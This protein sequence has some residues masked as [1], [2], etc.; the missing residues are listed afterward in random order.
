MSLLMA[1]LIFLMYALPAVAA[2]WI[3]PTK[4]LRSP[5]TCEYVD[6]NITNVSTKIKN[7]CY[8]LQSV[9]PTS[10]YHLE[11]DGRGHDAMCVAADRSAPGND[12]KAYKL[13]LSGLKDYKGSYSHLLEASA[14]LTATDSDYSVWFS[15]FYYSDLYQYNDEQILRKIAWLIDDGNWTYYPLSKDYEADDLYDGIELDFNSP[16]NDSNIYRDLKISKDAQNRYYA[17]DIASSRVGANISGLYGSAHAIASRII[18]G[19]RYHLSGTIYYSFTRTESDKGTYQRG[20]HATYA[21]GDNGNGRNNNKFRRIQ[22]TQYFNIIAHAPEYDGNLYIYS[23]DQRSGVGQQWLMYVDRTTDRKSEKAYIRPA[24]DKNTAGGTDMK[25]AEFTIYS[26]SSMSDVLGVI[27]DEDGNGYYSDYDNREQGDDQRKGLLKL[28]NNLD[29]TH[30]RTFYIKET[31][32]PDSLISAEGNK[33]ILRENIIDDNLY[34]VTVKYVYKTGK[35]TVDVSMDGS[36]VYSGTVKGYD[37]D[38]EPGNCYIGNN[39]DGDYV[40]GAGLK[41]TKDTSTGF[42][43]TNTVFS[44]YEGTDTDSSALAYYR[45]ADGWGWYKD[46]TGSDYLGSSYPVLPSAAYTLVEEYTPDYYADTGIPYTVI[47][48]SGWNRVGDNKYSYTFTTEGMSFGDEMTVKCNNDR[49]ESSITIS[50]ASDDKVIE[51]RGFDISYLG[52]GNSADSGDGVP[53]AHVET[54]SMG[55]AQLTDLPLGWYR[56]SETDP[57]DYRLTWAQGVNVRG[58]DAIVHLTSSNINSVTV[59]AMNNL[60]VRIAV[61]KKDAENGELIGGAVF[62]LYKDTDG[63]G[64]LDADEEKDYIELK[65]SD[66]D[67]IVVAE[68]VGVGKYLVRESQAPRGYYRSDD[69]IAFDIT[70]RTTD[71]IIVNGMEMRAYQG[72]IEDARYKAPVYVYKTDSSDSSIKLTGAEFRIYEDSNGNGTYDADTD[73][74]A[75]VNENGKTYDVFFAERNGRYETC[76]DDGTVNS[77]LLSFGTYFIEEVTA[78]E[79]YIRTK[80]IRK[81]VID[82]VDTSELSEPDPCEVTFANDK[83]FGTSLTGVGNSKNVELSSEAVLKDSVR[84]GNLVV[85]RTYTLK[86]ELMIRNEDGSCEHTGITAE[87]SFTVK[88]DGETR[89]SGSVEMKFVLDTNKYKG[90]TL[91]AYESLY[92]RTRLIGSH[93]DINDEGQTVRIPDIGTV[94]TADRTGTHTSPVAPGTTFTDMVRY[95]GLI[96]GDEYTLTGVLVDRETGEEL[97]DSESVLKP[98]EAD[99]IAEVHFELDTSELEGRSIVAFEYIS[100]GSSIVAKHD[101]ITDEDQTVGIPKLITTASSDGNKVMNVSAKTTI[102]DTVHY[103]NL[104]PGRMYVMEGSLMH[105]GSGAVYFDPRNNMVRSEVEFVPETPEGSVEV[106]FVFD[107]SN[108]EEGDKLVV[109]ETG[110]MALDDNEDGARLLLCEHRDPNNKD[111]TVSVRRDVPKT[112]DDGID[113]SYVAGL[114]AALGTVIALIGIGSLMSSRKADSYEKPD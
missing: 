60:S 50:K 78:P 25:G 112:G 37:G 38:G 105:S 22:L 88:A 15:A 9:D 63:D 2:G 57:E 87:K 82:R 35:L 74:T 10:L 27:T 34:K 26:D 1:S 12:G 64:F 80:R 42:D 68:G 30:S 29:G 24:A 86:G 40:D 107:S 96:A 84:Y 65:D 14:N 17:F 11:A 58:S 103:E 110:Y 106:K 45:Y 89:T 114:A 54:N 47:N 48:T 41:V 6:S 77:A 28:D 13:D 85:G 39:P 75:K 71:T 113:M 76:Y 111:Q 32:A 46:R 56:I 66:N 97:A 79:L 81:I 83:D 33:A 55:M 92:Y 95:E 19:D 21:Y 23:P 20:S 43:T 36:K 7:V 31:K 90:K 8:D 104:T 51:G 67:G 73:L 59:S 53:A 100:Y 3:D 99:G 101:D 91:V 102:V 94:L 16:I 108:L 69:V 109:Y 44:L 18:S 70:G 49:V 4:D 93:E 5:L 72:E 61:T 62:R 52:N 98:D